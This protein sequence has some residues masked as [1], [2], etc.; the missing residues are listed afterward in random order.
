[1]RGHWG[2]IHVMSGRG[3]LLKTSSFRAWRSA[4]STSLYRCY[5]S[6]VW[7]LSSVKLLS[8]WA[9]IIASSSTIHSSGH[10][11]SAPRSSTRLHLM[12][13]ML[14]GSCLN[15]WW[16]LLWGRRLVLWLITSHYHGWFLGLLGLYWSSF[17]WRFY[18]I[19]WRL[20]RLRRSL[21]TS[22]WWLLVYSYEWNR[23]I[24]T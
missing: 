3:A 21:D 17:F 12:W 5:S 13:L 4:H 8:W 14:L 6:C 19:W 20:L 10:H 18:W 22:L 23:C 9:L 15:R 2:R 16:L 7:W 11:S 1:M 24:N